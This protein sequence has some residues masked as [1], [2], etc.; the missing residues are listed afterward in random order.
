MKT[1]KRKQ[2]YCPSRDHQ[3]H[4]RYGN[5]TEVSSFLP[6][7]DDDGNEDT[8]TTKDNSPVSILDVIT[9]EVLQTAICDFL[10]PD[11][12]VALLH[13]N[14]IFDSY[15]Q[16]RMT[17]CKLHGTRLDRSY[18]DD[19]ER[20]QRQNNVCDDDDDRNDSNADVE[21]LIWAEENQKFI[22]ADQ[23][24][25]RIDTDCNFIDDEKPSSLYPDCEECRMAR[26][27]LKK[28]CRIC[29]DFQH[30][31]Y[32]NGTTRCAG[33]C[34]TSGCEACLSYMC[35][36]RNCTKSGLCY[37][38][39]CFDGFYCGYCEQEYHNAC[40]PS[41]KCGECNTVVYCNTCTASG[42]NE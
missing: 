42:H 14:E 15:E 9:G 16:L 7:N 37:C 38:E 33:K 26:F 10:V 20:K 25:L 35:Q 12:I 13:V 34:Q 31:T 5:E 41:T 24:T 36:D 28:K 29:K 8:K 40:V 22:L 1:K 3:H 30:Y 11:E 18:E 32:F 27:Y 19:V 39:T 6:R 21:F 2:L 4:Y 23:S 17:Y